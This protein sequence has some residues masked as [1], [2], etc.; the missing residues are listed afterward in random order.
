MRKFPWSKFILSM[1]ILAILAG[2]SGC[3]AVG[4]V[5][6]GTQNFWDELS[7]LPQRLMQALTN[8]MRSIG[9]VGAGLAESIRN[10]VGGM[11]GR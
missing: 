2:S 1:L 9:S 6:K 5:T 7:N 4:G 8:L 11:T 10:I 3:Q